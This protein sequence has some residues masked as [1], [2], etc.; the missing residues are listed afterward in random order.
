MHLSGQSELGDANVERLDWR[1]VILANGLILMGS[2]RDRSPG[3]P[4]STDGSSTR[5]GSEN[6][7]AAG[8]SFRS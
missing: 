7:N 1:L 2:S 4:Q 6:W 5:G 3:M 8:T